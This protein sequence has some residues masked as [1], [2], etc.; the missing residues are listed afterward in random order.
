MQQPRSNI[1]RAIQIKKSHMKH[2]AID[3]KHATAEVK[4]ENHINIVQF[5]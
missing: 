2:A 1:Q 4:Y 5:K 3:V